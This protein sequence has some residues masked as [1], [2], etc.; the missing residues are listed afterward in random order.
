MDSDIDS[1]G[2]TRD[3]H[4]MPDDVRLAIEGR[5]L[6]AAYRQRPAYQ[7]NDYVGWIARA[8][9]AATREK[10]LLQ[11]LDELER[12]GIYMHMKWRS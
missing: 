9:Q 6:M 3:I 12:G 2:L 7:Q 11:M 8:K 10:R 1:G 5:G 4:Q